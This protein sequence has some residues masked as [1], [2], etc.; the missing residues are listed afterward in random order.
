MISKNSW[1]KMDVGIGVGVTGS[2]FRFSKSLL[3]EINGLANHNASKNLTKGTRI[4][5][6]HKLYSEKVCETWDWVS[7]F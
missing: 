1:I 5:A 6:W 7:W 3:T 4:H 2:E